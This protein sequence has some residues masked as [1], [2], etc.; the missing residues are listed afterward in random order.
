MSLD[1]PS[2]IVKRRSTL[3]M[4]DLDQF[5]T[6][7]LDSKYPEDTR[8]FYSPHDDVHP[9][10]M[11]LLSEVRTSLVLSMFGF[12]DEE[13]ATKIDGILDDESI[14]TQITLDSTQYGGKTEHELLTRFKNFTPG[15]S[16]AIGR[17][18]KGEIIH[19]KMMIVNGVWLVTG[20]TN[21]SLNGE[22]RQDNELSVT[23]NAVACA[24]ARHILDLSHDKALMDTIRKYGPTP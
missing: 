6:F 22:Q 16:I 7:G 2:R 24:E 20:S 15:N 5:K 3:A 23:Y 21:W 17:S 1:N 14:Y 9:V 8:R 4:T 11:A 18:E 10:I 19:R 13:A 12:T